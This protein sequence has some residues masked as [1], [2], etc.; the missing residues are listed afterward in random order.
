[1][2]ARW[3][4]LVVL[5]ACKSAPHLEWIDAPAN[6]DVATLVQ[7]ELANSAGHHVVVYV[8]AKWCEP[9]QHFHTAA[10]SGALAQAFPNVRF[11]AFDLDRDRERLLAAGYMS[12]LIPLLVVKTD[13]VH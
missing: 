13:R 4:V 6:G 5:A 11:F 8:G 7:A 2:S 10:Q 1:M 9:C 3:L 12:P